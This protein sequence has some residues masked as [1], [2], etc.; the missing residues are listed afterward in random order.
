MDR[1]RFTLAA[2]QAELDDLASRLDRT[3]WPDSVAGAGWNYGTD[4]DYLKELVRYWRERFDWRAQERELNRLD[5]YRATIDGHGLHFVHVRGKG[6]RPLPILLSHG[7]PDSFTRMLKLIPRLTDPAAYGGDPA[8]AFDV[9]VP[10]LPGFGYSDRPSTPGFGVARIAALFAQLMRGLGYTRY[11]AHGGDWGSGVTEALAVQDA[12]H[13]VGI[14]LTDVPFWRMFTLPPAALTPAEQ[15]FLDAGKKW[16]RAE[17]GYFA[18]QATKPQTLA[19]GLNDSPAGLASWIVEKFRTWSDCDG[20]VERRFSKDEL[21]TN[22]MIYWLTQTIHS[23]ARTYYEAQQSLS[24]AAAAA[25]VEV[26]TG[27]A[28]FP[29]DLV[30][31]PREYAER[32]FDVRRYTEMP[33]GGHFAALEEPDLLAHE[34]REFFRPLR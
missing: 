22:V 8:D 19:V 25:R 12:E 18:I 17:G 31:A 24:A 13:L 5:H 29:K 21:L 28:I 32:F 30:R 4:L 27:V 20:D 9:V 1:T 6:E 7:F 15:R 2:P 10:S 16:Q 23:A 3:R 11:A 33:S 14:H 26:P 34:L